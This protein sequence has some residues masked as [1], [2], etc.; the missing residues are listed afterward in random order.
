M[1][2]QGSSSLPVQQLPVWSVL[3][4]HGELTVGADVPTAIANWVCSG[5]EEMGGFNLSG[6]P[7]M[8]N[9]SNLF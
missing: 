3:L 4:C 9:S 5:E 1:F 8:A 6:C 2:H 7:Q